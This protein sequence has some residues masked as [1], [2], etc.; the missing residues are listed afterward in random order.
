MTSQP[1]FLLRFLPALLVLY[2]LTRAAGA[3][4]NVSKPKTGAAA[5]AVLIGASAFLISKQSFLWF[6][7]T[8]RFCEWRASRRH[9]R[10]QMR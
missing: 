7:W 10:S 5:M 1:L 3:L 2:F 4:F 6:D 9:S 8:G